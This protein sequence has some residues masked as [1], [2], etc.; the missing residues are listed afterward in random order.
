MTAL[1]VSHHFKTVYGQEIA[2]VA[3]RDNIPLALLA[4]PADREARLPDAD[5]ARIAT[6]FFSEDVFP[7]FSR[8]FFSAVRKASA[9]KWMHVFNAGVD[10][11]IYTEML[12]RGVR[13]TTSSGS[14]AE[15]I[16]HTAITALLMLARNFP[17]WLEGQSKRTWNPMRVPNMPRDL[18]EQRVLILGLG[19]IGNEIARLARAL[20]MHVTAVRRS[21][22]TPAD[23]VDALYPPAQLATLLPTTDWL[24]IACPLT[25]ETRG[26]IDAALIAK[27]PTG[28][29]IINIARGEIIDEAAL[30]AALQS[31]HV[32]GAYLDVFEK[33]P[34]AP[35][36][37]LWALPNVFVT[38]HNSAAASGNQQRVNAIFFDN[39]RRWQ[40][41][42]ALVNEV[43]ARDTE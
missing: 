22:K 26:M 36:S 16:A 31:G 34:L 3:A 37:P 6:A 11:P 43:R 23:D 14:T 15:P 12:A 24:I 29:R 38:P 21:A 1:L 4:L 9:L 25:G 17:R 33:E 40:R 32:A 10:H 5:C 7:D 2:A 42:A 27:L 13:L 39:L 8:Q 35:E 19:Q 41:G 28:A 18:N 20:G 30:V